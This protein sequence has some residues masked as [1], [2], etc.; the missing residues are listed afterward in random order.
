MRAIILEK[1]GG[2]ENLRYVEDFPA[3]QPKVGEVRVRVRAAALNRLDLW[4]R[5]GWEGIKLPLPHILGADAAGE[6]EAIGNGVQGLAVGD[7]V[8][9]NPGISCGQ[10]ELCLSGQD[11]LCPKFGILGEDM[12]GTYAEYVVVPA[13]NALKLPDHVSYEQAAA[14]ALVY[15][16]AWHSLITR[17]NLKAGES[18]LIVGA[19]G[20]VNSAS[21]QI[22]KLA[23][24]TVYVVASNAEKAAQAQA[25]GADVCIDRSAEDWSRAIFRLTER[26]GVDVVVDNV[27]MATINSSIRAVRRGG[28]ILIV[29]NTSGY[30]AN[31]DM[32]YLFA[33]HISLIGSTMAPHADF[34]QVMRLVFAGKLQPLISARYPLAEAAQAQ[35]R[36]AKGDVFGKIVLMV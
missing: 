13:R 36:L 30:S 6:I 28:R 25:L 27:G 3:P 11:N 21:I 8:V 22:A 4:V 14:A 7:R 24:A 12:H 34:L 2:I 29:G 18:V 31:I 10:C 23:G 1:H 16:T 17:G 15:L 35:E 20:G 33:K 26:R 19:G 9:L 5:E 32:R